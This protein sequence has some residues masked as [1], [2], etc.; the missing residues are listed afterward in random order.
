MDMAFFVFCT[1]SHA[2][3]ESFPDWGL[4]PELEAAASG[5]EI[6]AAHSFNS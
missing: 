6:C 5:P 3:I 2:P 1:K 4:L